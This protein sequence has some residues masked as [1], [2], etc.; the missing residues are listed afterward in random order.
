MRK[1]HTPVLMTSVPGYSTD[2]PLPTPHTYSLVTL[3]F[4]IKPFPFK[5]KLRKASLGVVGV[6]YDSHL[7]PTIPRPW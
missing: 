4:K 3:Y 1:D 5:S 7:S 6:A 2:I